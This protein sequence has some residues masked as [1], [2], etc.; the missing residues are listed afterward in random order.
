M[1]YSI[2][3]SEHPVVFCANPRTGSTAL[4]NTLLSM[5]A[6]KEG[7]HHDPP[8]EVREG[9]LVVETVRHHCDVFV[10]WWFWR[11]SSISFP[12]FVRMVMDGQHPMLRPNQLYGRFDSNYILRY[13]TLDFE[14]ETLCVSAGLDHQKIE[15]ST[16]TKRPKNIKWDLLFPFDLRRQVYKMY[17]EEMERLGYGTA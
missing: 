10:S 1:S 5:G 11:N 12:K 7:E 6:V 3:G 14:W 4:A 9:T 13:E 8:T 17:G 15:R 16:N 2:Q